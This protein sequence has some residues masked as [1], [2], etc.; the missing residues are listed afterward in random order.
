MRCY[1]KKI[2][3]IT[4]DQ[5]GDQVS[6]QVQKLLSEMGNQYYSTQELMK[7]LALTRKPT[8]RQH[9]LNPALQAG[10]VVMKYPESPRSP[11]QA[12]RKVTGGS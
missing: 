8:F 2:T 12:Y 5:V 4:G 3:V 1:A 11:K 7:K 9:Y 10:L 6:D